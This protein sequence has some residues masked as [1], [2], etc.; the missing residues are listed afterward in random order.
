M[1][2]GWDEEVLGPSNMVNKVSALNW[3]ADGTV[4]ELVREE[5]VIAWVADVKI[6]SPIPTWKGIG[7]V[8]VEE[9]LVDGT[10]LF[11]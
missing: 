2:I 5:D 9:E 8:V 3:L 6:D 4:E 1:L 10:D 7:G 11:N